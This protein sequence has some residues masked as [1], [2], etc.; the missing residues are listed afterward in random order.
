MGMRTKRPKQDR[1]DTAGDDGCSVN[2]H[3]Q[4]RPAM[5][6]AMHAAWRV[7]DA[8]SRNDWIRRAIADALE[9][10]TLDRQ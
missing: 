3:L 9:T 10:Q 7:S 2:I 6:D 8:S 5:R 1:D 4:I